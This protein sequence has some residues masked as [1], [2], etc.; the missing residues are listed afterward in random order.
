MRL[1]RRPVRPR[2]DRA[3]ARVALAVVGSALLFFLLF[4]APVFGSGYMI[5][6]QPSESQTSGSPSGSPTSSPSEGPTGSPAPTGPS[7]ALLNPS[8]AYAPF[9]PDAQ[10]LSEQIPQISDMLDADET[11]HVVATTNSAPAGATAAAVWAA[12]GGGETTIG[13]LTQ[14]G[15]TG[16]WGVS[17]NVPD[18]LDGQ[19]GRVIARLFSGEQK[20]AEN[21]VDAEIDLA[22]ETVELTWPTNGG[23][24][25]FFKSSSGPWRFVLDGIVSEAGPRVFVSYSTTPHGQAPTFDGDCGFVDPDPQTPFQ[26]TCT[27]AASHLPSQVTSI[28]MVA[29]E[30]DNPLGT[31]LLTQD[32]ADVHAVVPYLQDP[33]KMNVSIEAVA[34]DAPDATYP[35]GARR[36]MGTGC[37]AYDVTVTDHLERPVQGANVDVHVQGPVDEAGSGVAGSTASGSSG[38]KPPDQQAHV[39][40][41]AWD[42]DSPGDHV[43]TEGRH[44]DPDTVDRKHFES[45]LGTGLGPTGIDP[46]QFRFHVF[47][48]AA[49]DMTMTAWVDE[50]PNP[51]A[52]DGLREINDDE[53]EKREPSGA[54][55]AQWLPLPVSVS[56]S[57]SGEASLIGTCKAFRVSARAGAALLDGVNVDVH[58]TGPSNDLDFCDPT[59]N[60]TLQAPTEGEHETESGETDEASHPSAEAAVPRVQHAEGT[61]DEQGDLLIGLTSPVSGDTTLSAWVDGEPEQDNDL[62]ETDEAAGVASM[63]WAATAQDARVRFVNPSGYGGGGDNVSNLPDTDGLYHVVTRVDLADLVQGVEIL[64]SSDGQSF[65]KLGDAVRVGN[66]DVFEF[67]W[68][69]VTLDAGTY[70]LRARVAGTQNVED[71]EVAVDNAQQTTEI[72]EP[73]VGGQAVFTNKEVTVSGK[74]SSGAEGVTLY[75]TTTG[76]NETRGAEQWTECGAVTLATAEGPQDFSGKC[77]LADSNTPDHVTAVAAL[78]TTCDPDFG[79]D[80]PLGGVILDSGD[81]HAVAGASA[82]PAISI[83]AD[84]PGDTGTCHRVDVSV[85]D[86]AGDPV[87]NLNVDVHLSGPTNNVSFC[88]VAGGSAR[89]APNDGGHT[90]RPGEGLHSSPNEHHTE[91]ETGSGGRLIVGIRS[92]QSGVS[93]IEAWIDGDDEDVRDPNEKTARLAFEWVAPRGCSQVGTPGDDVLT[94]TSGPDRICGRGGDDVLVGKRGKDVLLGGGGNDV[95]RGQGGKDVL[96]GGKGRDTLVGGGGRDRVR[97]GAGDDILKGGKGRDRLNGGGGKD[98]LD[99]GAK[100]DRCRGGPGRDRERR[101]E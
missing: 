57:P 84:E 38:R 24:L 50:E 39:P 65:T 35:A 67:D 1:F 22:E 11:Y 5:N 79:C 37:L 78:A 74:A 43:G 4:T 17:W 58:A 60:A 46:G 18:A 34:P 88:E 51:E 101:C 62:P 47:S 97:G 59:G 89:R 3:L 71:R 72:A 82:N 77:K 41:E 99:G 61:T 91:G 63:S 53:Q 7:I 45:T 49:G 12:T 69:L 13:P 21:A 2:N 15:D 70:T 20:L 30:P 87:A 6:A 25:G 75:Y 28:A 93:E 19:T 100:R 16:A 83:T 76:P 64:L 29:T 85:V 26:V 33:A 32:S 66:T 48:P 90:M 73:A 86:G 40:A 96:K 92:G 81:A 54:A 36:E 9:A 44:E 31:G 23:P 80:A 42:C 27:L 10:P 8:A 52:E 94:G 56:I 95:I 14:V 98:R 68:N 55:R